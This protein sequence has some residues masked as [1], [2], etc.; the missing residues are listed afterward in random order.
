MTQI[1]TNSTETNRIFG[2]D[3]LRGLA[4][5]LMVLS[6][7]IAHGILPDWMYHAQLPPP[8]HKFNPDL[9]GLTWVDLVFPLFLFCM[10]A[11]FPLALK[12]YV[13][14]PL[15]GVKR[16]LLRF[17][18]LSAFAIL[19]QHVRPGHLGSLS[20]SMTWVWA[21]VGFGF[22]FLMYTKWPKSF[23]KLIGQILT[24]LGWIGM[25]AFVSL[26]T[27]PKTEGFDLYRSDII[28]I[29]LSNMALFGGLFWLFTAKKPS[30]R[31][32]IL[33]IYAALRLSSTN[34]GWIQDVWSYSPLPWL[35][36][37]DYLKYLV[38]VIP[39]MFAGEYVM[40]EMKSIDPKLSDK[41]SSFI[42]LQIVI[43]ILNITLFVGL[44]SRYVFF[45]TL[46]AGISCFVILHLSKKT[47]SISSS[48]HTLIQV[49]CFWLMLGLLLEP[50]AGGMKKD[51]S[52][53]TY[54]MVTAGMSGLLLSTFVYLF[55]VLKL[56]RA[57][58]LIQ[59]GQNPMIAYVAFANIIW[60]ILALSGLEV[61]INSMTHTPI[62]GFLRGVLYTSL[63]AL[64]TKLF[65]TQ[66][67]FWK[68]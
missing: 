18:Y 34:V 61:Y 28:L 44:Q 32:G 47:W 24:G 6:G 1:Q 50:Y 26:Y 39:G 20:D 40:Q 62:L 65:T 5:L 13:E 27:Y 31:Y 4:I 10:G 33:I 63:V 23:S 3:A 45:T 52:S 38:I 41:K 9:P 53:F 22:L 30:L 17:F 14:N 8:T 19:L 16:I 25:I 35:M 15:G 57:Q 58:W 60:P 55:D 37:W 36:K 11:A 29:V 12:R 21:L 59:N 43:L 67:I 49:S 2:L 66:K 64:I 7:V 54:W 46:I 68:T 42:A 48:I 56:K 51:P